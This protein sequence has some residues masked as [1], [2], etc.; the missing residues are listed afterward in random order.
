M[1]HA[2]PFL[3]LCFFVGSRYLL[4]AKAFEMEPTDDSAF[5]AFTTAL[6]SLARVFPGAGMGYV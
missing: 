3:P 5:N 4:V 6:E 2:N 1:A